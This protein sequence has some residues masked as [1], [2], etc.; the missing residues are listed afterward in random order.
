[1]CLHG[2][3]SA[4]LPLYAR[5]ITKH[6]AHTVS[7]RVIRGFSP[8][9]L[10]QARQRAGL[11]RQDLARLARTGRAT[12]DNWE[13]GRATPQ[14]DVLVRVATVLGLAVDKLVHIPSHQRFPGD[15][16][17]LRGFTQPQLAVA[18][19]L[20]TTTIGAIER[21]EVALTDTNAAAISAALDMTSRTYRQAYERA[22][23][24]PAGTPA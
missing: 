20:S 11:S 17:V 21:G 24:R 14:I 6:P 10:S 18:T 2:V 16:R 7:R 15:W 9:A 8:A 1:M 12:I 19:G 23:T 22:R 13:S 4:T 5:V 3:A